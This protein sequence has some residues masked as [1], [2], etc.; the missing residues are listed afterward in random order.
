L[1]AAV[2]VLGAVASLGCEGFRELPLARADAT[3][4]RADA[5]DAPAVTDGL[6]VTEPR[7]GSDAPSAPVDAGPCGGGCPTGETCC[8]GRCVDVETDPANCGSCAATCTAP[9]ASSTCQ[10]GR[11]VNLCQ[12]GFGDC[13]R[14]GQNGCEVDLTSS[15]FHCGACGAACPMA[16][17]SAV[18]DTGRCRIVSC[19]PGWGNC[20]GDAANGCEANIQT[21]ADH[22]NGCDNP[23]QQ[24][25]NGPYCDGP[26]GCRLG[27]CDAD[28][29][30]C[31]GDRRDGCETNTS[32]DVQNCGACGRVCP[33][34][35]G[36]TPTCAAGACGTAPVMCAAPLAECDGVVLPAATQC[37]TDVRASATHCG[38]CGNAC[39]T[40]NATSSCA[41]GACVLSC[42]AGYGD[43]DGRVTTGCETSTLTAVAHCGACGRACDLP[44][45]DGHA[46]VAGAC[47]AVTCDAGFG[48]CDGNPA[49]GCETDTRASPAH[50]GAC[51]RACATPNAAPACAAALC[52]V[53]ACAA[54]FGNCDGNAAN[55]C[56]SDTRRD[57]RNCGACGRACSPLANGASQCASGACALAACFPGFGNC[58]GNAANG[59]ETFVYG[60]PRNC[61]ACGRVCSGV[62]LRCAAGTCVF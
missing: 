2:A 62:T 20:D 7:D 5:S 18:C 24:N 10:S 15:A 27:A 39:S 9:N 28:W 53:G 60:D 58:D 26:A 47:R 17:E 45:V 50:C 11:C 54:G 46:C 12:P 16:R 23:C 43:C 59:C 61:G 19:A 42:L 48:D 30:D 51:G 57:V 49:N 14:N 31:N 35:R 36:M 40:V 56:E 44:R 55:G 4:D 25:H 32:G 29:A 3:A 34:D 6:D 52:A 1:C 38:R 37:E 8:E 33:P 13:D 22:C 41:A 21:S